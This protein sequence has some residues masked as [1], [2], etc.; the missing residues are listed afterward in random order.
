[1][2]AK[3]LL[4]LTDIVEKICRRSEGRFDLYFVLVVMMEAGEINVIEAMHIM[5]ALHEKGTTFFVVDAAGIP[6]LQWSPLNGAIT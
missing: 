4:R 2:E 1:M 3:R 5:R 6:Q